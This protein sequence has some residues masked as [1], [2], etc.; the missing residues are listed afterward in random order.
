M[1]D[2][3]V[4]LHIVTVGEQEG[5]EFIIKFDEKFKPDLI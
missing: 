3:N 2:I 1:I 5:N 4:T